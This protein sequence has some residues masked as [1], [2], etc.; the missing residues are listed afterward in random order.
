MN[1]KTVEKKTESHVGAA[2]TD[3]FTFVLGSPSNAPVSSDDSQ[4]ESCPVDLNEVSGVWSPSEM[5]AWL[6]FAS[7]EGSLSSRSIVEE[8][9][10]TVSIFKL[11]G[12]Q[13]PD[14]KRKE[15]LESFMKCKHRA[16]LFCTDVASVCVQNSPGVLRH[17]SSE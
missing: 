2:K 6:R 17:F 14:G 16:I 9:S 15:A 5:L 12:D 13:L 7:E 4:L 11:R 1:L 10:S 3:E 8:V